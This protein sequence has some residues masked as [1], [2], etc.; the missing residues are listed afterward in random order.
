MEDQERVED[1][2]PRLSNLGLRGENCHGCFANAFDPRLVVDV[3][4]RA[5]SAILSPTRDVRSDLPRGR[6]SARMMCP[7]RRIVRCGI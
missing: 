2:N 4:D 5:L 1:Q 7:S 3:N 6:T